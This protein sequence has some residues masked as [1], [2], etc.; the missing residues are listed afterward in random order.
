V[1]HRALSLLASLTVLLAALVGTDVNTRP[2]EAAIANAFLYG[3]ESTA[4]ALPRDRA[5]QF[6][7]AG[8]PLRVVPAE[9]LSP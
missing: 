7:V 6:S 5:D 9:H 1:R 3:E 8:S 2:A 4:S